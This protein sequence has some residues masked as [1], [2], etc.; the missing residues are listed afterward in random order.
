M[1]FK[2]KETGEIRD[3]TPNMLNAAL[4]SAQNRKRLFW[5]GNLINNSYEAVCVPPPEDRGIMLKD[6][7]TAATTAG[8]GGDFPGPMR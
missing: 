5:V 1:K 6:I 8:N 7:S 2:N 4:V 3:C